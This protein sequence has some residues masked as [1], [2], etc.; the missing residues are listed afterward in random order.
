M[1]SWATDTA[2]PETHLVQ[3]EFELQ[4]RQFGMK[5]E[6]KRH[7]PLPKPGAY[8]G[9]HDEQWVESLQTKQLGIVTEH[10]WQVF[11]AVIKA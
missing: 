11:V 8:S 4:W 10:A 5:N 3:V 2:Y 6:H 9:W 7:E 1:Q